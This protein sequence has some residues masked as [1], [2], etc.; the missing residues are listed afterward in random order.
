MSNTT[1]Y[2]LF[3]AIGN[4][5]KGAAQGQM[6]GKPCFKTGGKAFVCFFEN[7]MVFKLTGIP[8]H[9]ALQLNGAKLFDPSGKNRPMK[10]W[11]QVP[12]QHSTLWTKLA[13]EANSFVSGM[14]E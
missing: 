2:E 7:E 9:E 4:N 10:E 3:S 13:A 6:F 12:E 14:L 11:V 1:A 8:H 5:L